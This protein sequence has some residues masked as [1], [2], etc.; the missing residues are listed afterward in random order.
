MGGA[1]NIPRSAKSAYNRKLS[2]YER[3]RW[4]LIKSRFPGFTEEVER[5]FW[6]IIDEL[7]LKPEDSE[8]A[9]ELLK[10]EPALLDVSDQS[11]KDLHVESTDNTKLLSE[12]LQDIYE[13]YCLF[14]DAVSQNESPLCVIYEGAET[15]SALADAKDKI[16]N[17][18]E[19]NRILSDKLNRTEIDIDS[20]HPRRVGNIY[21]L[22]LL[23]VEKNYQSKTSNQLL[24][25]ICSS[26]STKNGKPEIGKETIKSILA[27]ARSHFQ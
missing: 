11:S 20:L 6:Y 8:F 13:S 17:L 7:G 27:D 25:N 14:D 2:D 12:W 26:I 3:L 22:I 21:R 23:L 5:A 24:D 19:D 10:L 4:L 9:E 1:R 18:T 16:S 15:A